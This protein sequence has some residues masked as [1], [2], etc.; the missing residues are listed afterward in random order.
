M[1]AE[2]KTVTVTTDAAGDAEE[3]SVVVNGRVLEIVYTKSDFA[4]GVDFTITTESTAQNLWVEADVNASKVCR[5]RPLCQDAAGADL[6][7][8][9]S[10]VVVAEERIKIVV[11]NGGN[12]K[13]GTFQIVVG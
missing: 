5:P 11:A 6:A 1:H 7:A 10:P 4:A 12:A 13:N 3:Y 9:Y 2:R 8:E